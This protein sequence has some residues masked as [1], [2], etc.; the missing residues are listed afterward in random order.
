MKRFPLFVGTALLV[1]CT[2]ITEPGCACSPPGGG[3]GVITGTVTSPAMAPVA[4]A[5]V[6]VRLMHDETC[7]DPQA[8]VVRTVQT[9]VSGRF[10]H[11]ESWSGGRKCFRVWAEAPQGSTLA[12]SDSQFVRVDFLDAG[13]TPDS[14]E[15][16]FQL[17]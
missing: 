10:R 2:A 1:A 15:L 16:T 4:G 3:T 6:Q 8:T 14:V 11:T 17:R 7:T 9:N 5:A 12:R 13:V